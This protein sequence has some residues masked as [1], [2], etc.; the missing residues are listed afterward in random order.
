MKPYVLEFREID[1][2]QTFA[3]RRKRD[4]FRGTVEDSRNTSTRRILCY[5]RSL[6][7]SHRTKR[8]LPQL[9]DQLTLL[10]VDESRSN[11]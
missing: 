11:W 4:E 8:S 1:K 10:K 2:T 6:S 5:D 3:G 9:L 7:K